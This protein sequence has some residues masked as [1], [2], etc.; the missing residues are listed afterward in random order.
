MEICTKNDAYTCAIVAVFLLHLLGSFSLCN[1]LQ[2]KS[3]C[4]T[5]LETL[6]YRQTSKGTSKFIRVPGKMG[7]FGLKLE[8][9]STSSTTTRP[10]EHT[11]SVVQQLPSQVGE[12]AAGMAGDGMAS[13]R[14]E[15]VEQW[16][17][18][19]KVVYKRKKR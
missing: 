3:S 2:V 19:P 10:S 9:D 12:T 6:L 15:G 14:R 18:H 13:G 1:A 5:S 11:Q 7:W 8:G 16:N 17:F 4:S